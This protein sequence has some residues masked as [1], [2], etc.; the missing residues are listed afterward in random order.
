MIPALGLL[1]RR[2][3]PWFLAEPEVLNSGAGE[4]RVKG[5]GAQ[6]ARVM[7]QC[8]LPVPAQRT[9]T[10]ASACQCA[11]CMRHDMSSLPPLPA[12]ALSNLSPY[13]HYGQLAPQRA[14]LEA[15]KHRSK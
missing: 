13:L 6:R 3:W 8:L 14:A 10:A 2:R 11:A 1:L 4:K 9:T 15:A 5:W 7:Q 12:Q